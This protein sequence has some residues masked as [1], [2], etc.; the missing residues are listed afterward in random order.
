MGEKSVKFQSKKFYIFKAKKCIS[1]PLEVE[2]GLLDNFV[3]VEQLEE[4][5]HNVALVVLGVEEGQQRHNFVVE[6]MGVQ[7]VD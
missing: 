1:L 2:L 6:Q 7:L 4:Q 3:E 5:Q